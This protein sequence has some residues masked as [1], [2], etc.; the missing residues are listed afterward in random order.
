MRSQE[1]LTIIRMWEEVGKQ[2]VGQDAN[3]A[4]DMV[5]ENK[6][7]G[8]SR[9]VVPAPPLALPMGMGQVDGR[10]GRH[11]RPLIGDGE[12]QW[13]TGQKSRS[14]SVSRDL[15]RRRMAMAMAMNVGP[16]AHSYGACLSGAHDL[17][18]VWRQ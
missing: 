13:G 2:V 15:T 7:G 4:L 18:R 5:V 16:A 8:N 17:A 3:V 9:F 14:C 12:R 6:T 11:G 10:Q 1:R